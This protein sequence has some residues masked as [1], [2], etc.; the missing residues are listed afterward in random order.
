MFRHPTQLRRT[1]FREFEGLSP[2]EFRGE[3]RR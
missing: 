2:T 3:A 1:L